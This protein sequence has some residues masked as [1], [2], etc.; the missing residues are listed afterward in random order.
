MQLFVPYVKTVIFGGVI[1]E[2]HAI[3]I[4]VS[5]VKN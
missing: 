4:P 3:F 1:D 2:V 5:L